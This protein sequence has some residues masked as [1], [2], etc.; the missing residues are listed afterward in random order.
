MV[1]SRLIY[2][3]LRVW[4]L[5]VILNNPGIWRRFFSISDAY[6]VVSTLLSLPVSDHMLEQ[7]FKVLDDVT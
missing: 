3:G 5:K 4:C 7:T 2:G 6:H 1:S